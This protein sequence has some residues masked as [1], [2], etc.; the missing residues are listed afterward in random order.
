MKMK[1]LL[2]LI[3][4]FMSVIAYSQ[5]CETITGENRTLK[6]KLA[7]L[8]DTTQNARIKSFDSR[9]KV[10]VSSVIGYK[11]QQAVEIVFVISHDKVHQQ[12]CVNF[13]TKDLQ[14]YDEQGNIYDTSHG[15]IGVQEGMNYGGNASLCEKIPTSIPVKSAIRLRK[16]LPSVETIKKLI[17]KIGYRD[18]DGNQPYNYGMIEFDNLKI[19]W[20]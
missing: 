1:N 7:S 10:E 9:F 2:G 16:V 13:G 5:N 20:K 18:A 11:E 19:T 14:A 3:V 15:L 12:V 4:L 6:A 17:L 8:I